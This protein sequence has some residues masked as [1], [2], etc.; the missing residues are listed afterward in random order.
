MPPSST[1]ATL[2]VKDDETQAGPTQEVATGQTRLPATDNEN[3]ER[4]G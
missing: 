1:G 4:F 3:I 2:S